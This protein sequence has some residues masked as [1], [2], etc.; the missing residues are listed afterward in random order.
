MKVK[1]WHI[2]TGPFHRDELP[3]Q[4]TYDLPDE[5]TY[6]MVI[7]TE[8]KVPKKKK[9]GFKTIIE[10]REFWFPDMDSVAAIQKHFHTS[11]EPLKMEL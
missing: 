5:M 6:M 10:D 4:D 8:A 7:K 2:V 11:I 3:P 9:K 1:L